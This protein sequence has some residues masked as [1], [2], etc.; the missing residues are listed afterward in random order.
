MFDPAAGAEICNVEPDP[1]TALT[2]SEIV[3]VLI[4]RRVSSVSNILFSFILM[5]GI[6]EL[7]EGLRKRSWRKSFTGVADKIAGD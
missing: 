7:L 3:V 2:P 6:Y 4:S 1:M 5:M